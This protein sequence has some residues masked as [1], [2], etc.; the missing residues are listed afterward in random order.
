[1][2]SHRKKW[3]KMCKLSNCQRKNCQFAHNFQQQAKGIARYNAMN[4]PYIISFT[5]I[6]ELI[7]ELKAELKHCFAQCVSTD[8]KIK[9][10]EQYIKST[11]EFNIS[12]NMFI[13]QDVYM[14]S[15]LTTTIS[16]M[17]EAGDFRK[18]HEILKD[19][20]DVRYRTTGIYLMTP[21]THTDLEF[22]NN[23]LVEMSSE[24]YDEVYITIRQ[25]GISRLK[26]TQ[27]TILDKL[28]KMTDKY[29][30]M[31]LYC[32][33]IAD[34]NECMGFD[35]LPRDPYTKDDF[36]LHGKI[37]EDLCPELGAII[38]DLGSDDFRLD[39][40][41]WLTYR[42]LSSP[43]KQHTACNMTGQGFAGLGSLGPLYPPKK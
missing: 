32:R 27:H 1:M 39:L 5:N 41:Q 3:T 7:D 34:H 40:G 42:P 26:Y 18:K 29:D 37:L 15:L 30:K 22:C 25:I 19:F 16:N 2:I 33:Y 6:E 31:K 13:P 10:F 12:S 20:L 4:P 43:A 21:Y 23:A 35:Q 38:K 9:V 14:E 17:K 28:S 24:L 36:A 8:D 11:S